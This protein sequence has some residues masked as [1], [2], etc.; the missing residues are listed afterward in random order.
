MRGGIIRTP[1]ALVMVPIAG[2][3]A[4]FAITQT[5]PGAFIGGLVCGALLGWRS[6]NLLN[7]LIA[8]AIIG[9]IGGLLLLGT[10][11]GLASLDFTGM[12]LDIDM[13]IFM[14][15]VA[16]AS[17]GSAAGS[18]GASVVSKLLSR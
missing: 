4:G 7:T 5:L 8:G 1:V 14:S 2:M 15:V 9:A 12:F 18:I 3:I 11:F 17:A 6:D 10:L 13:D 16:A